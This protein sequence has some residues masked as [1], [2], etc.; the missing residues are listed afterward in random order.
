MRPVMTTPL[1]KAK[2]RRAAK[3][4]VITDV[5]TK[6]DVILNQDFD[7]QHVAEVVSY[8]ESITALSEEIKQYDDDIFDDLL[9]EEIDLNNDEKEAQEYRSKSKTAQA[10]IK[11][12]LRNSKESRELATSSSCSSSSPCTNWICRYYPDALTDTHVTSAGQPPSQSN[13]YI[14]R[15]TSIDAFSAFFF[16]LL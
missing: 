9:E 2:R 1:D 14:R 7:E 12:Y 11:I 8:G 4:T 10:K 15:S 16:L 13:I 5:I 6:L 3:R